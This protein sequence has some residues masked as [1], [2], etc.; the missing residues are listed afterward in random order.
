M[1]HYVWNFRDFV[2]VYISFGPKPPEL[3]EKYKIDIFYS[4]FNQ[5]RRRVEEND[6][7]LHEHQ[8]F[9]YPNR[10]KIRIEKFNS[11]AQGQIF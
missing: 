8:H 6:I 5:F 10:K 9:K 11:G 4:Y 1:P 7:Y 2:C 3:N